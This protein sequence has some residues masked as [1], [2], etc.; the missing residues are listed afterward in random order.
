MP[1]STVTNIDPPRPHNRNQRRAA[2]RDIRESLTAHDPL[3]TIERC[4]AAIEQIAGATGLDFTGNGMWLPDFTY[5]AIAAALRSAERQLQQ[6]LDAK[7][8]R[9]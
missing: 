5:S 2:Y 6:Q 9:Q 4:R 7:G 8:T 3:S 1:N